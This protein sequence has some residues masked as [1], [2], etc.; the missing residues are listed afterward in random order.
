MNLVT[1]SSAAPLLPV[2]LRSPVEFDKDVRRQQRDR[3]FNKLER[4]HKLNEERKEI[5]DMSPVAG[6][7]VRLNSMLPKLF[8]G[9]QL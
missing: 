1:P 8:I 6:S 2:T 4:N 5:R 9:Q 7:D 3:F